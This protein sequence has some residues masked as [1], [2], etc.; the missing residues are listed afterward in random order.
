M[1]LLRIKKP[2]GGWLTLYHQDLSGYKNS[3]NKIDGEGTK[4]NMAATMRRQVIANKFKLEVKTKSPLTESEVKE[5]LLCL[6]QDTFEVEFHTSLSTEMMSMK[7]YG[8]TP[9]EE[10]DDVYVYPDGTE[11][12]MYKAMSFSL[13]E[14]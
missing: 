5:I 8:G 12:I 14:L 3:H 9:V 11:E 2:S 4:R 6:R 13:I 10:I 7:N 1:K